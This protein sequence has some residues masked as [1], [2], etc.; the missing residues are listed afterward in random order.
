MFCGILG[1]VLWSV[2]RLAGVEVDRD[3]ICILERLNG[4]VWLF[5][6]I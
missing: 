2:E 3:E 4:N 6:I 1:E 5:I